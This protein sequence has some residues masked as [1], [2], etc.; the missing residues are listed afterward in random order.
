MNTFKDEKNRFKLWKNIINEYSQLNN[1][2]INII[3]I[4]VWKGDFAKYILDNCE[5]INKYYLIDPWKKLDNWNKPFNVENQ[6]FVKIYNEV[7][8][9]LNVH[10]D[11]TK[12]HTEQSF[13]L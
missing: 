10:K 7:C 3:E 11:K 9:K 12:N 4:G 13:R 5:C 1:I 8:N 2:K 6:E